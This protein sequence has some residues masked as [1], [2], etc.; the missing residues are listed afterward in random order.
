MLLD[1]PIKSAESQRY[2]ALPRHRRRIILSLLKSLKF[3][4]CLDVGSAQHD[5]L[6][7]I[8][9][10]FNINT[11]ACDISEAI[12]NENKIKMPDSEFRVLDIERET[13]PNKT[14]DLVIC[15]EVIEHIVHWE[16]AVKNLTQMAKHYL[17]ITVPSGK[18]RKTDLIVGHYRHYQGDELISCLKTNGFKCAELKQHGFPMHSLY[19]LLINIARPETLYNSFHSK[20]KYTLVK[21]GFAHLIYG[22]FFM[23]YFFSSGNQLY[24][25][26]ERD[27]REMEC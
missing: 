1:Q 27:D 23:D 7:D 12:V 4:D 3:S 25:L 14:F 9:R 13:W 8:K 20:D 21:K 26:A 6:D 19:K 2:L 16:A 5:L 22:L 15:S 17:L 11:Y 10:N 18:I 24:I